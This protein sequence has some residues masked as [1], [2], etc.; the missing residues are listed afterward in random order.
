MQQNAGWSRA[1]SGRSSTSKFRPG[2]AQGQLRAC[3]GGN[4]TI[5]VVVHSAGLHWSIV[6]VVDS[7]GLD[8]AIVVVVRDSSSLL[9][10]LRRGEAHQVGVAGWSGGAHN[11]Q[12]QQPRILPKP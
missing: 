1:K 11:T 12:C 10:G 3:G 9:G 2:A 7:A 8:G 4:R 6:V 5:V